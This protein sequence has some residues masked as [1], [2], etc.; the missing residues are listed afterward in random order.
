VPI[1]LPNSAT[2][3]EKIDGPIALPNSATL[4]EQADGTIALPNS[5]TLMEKEAGSIALPNSATVIEKAD[6][7]IALPNSATLIEQPD[8]PIAL[9]NSA[10]LMEKIDGDL[11]TAWNDLCLSFLTGT[12]KCSDCKNM[13]QCQPI[14]ERGLVDARTKEKLYHHWATNSQS[15]DSNSTHFRKIKQINY[16]VL[17]RTSVGESPGSP[18]K[19]TSLHHC[20]IQGL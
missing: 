1:A 7:P 4:L 18:I 10:T 15:L 17:V 14:E 11:P 12:S 3:L 9:P 2:L 20:I 6:G 19:K 16:L 13:N 8:G 5:A